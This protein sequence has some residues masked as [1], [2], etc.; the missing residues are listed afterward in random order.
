MSLL[1]LLACLLA[2]HAFPVKGR[3]PLMAFYGRMCLSAARRLNAGDRNSGILAWFV[4]MGALMIPV[5]LVAVTLAA[6][7]IPARRALTVDPM[8]T[9]R[10]E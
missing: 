10:H 7:Y 8:M 4:L 9:L 6:T 5:A 3:Q 2:Q 1:A